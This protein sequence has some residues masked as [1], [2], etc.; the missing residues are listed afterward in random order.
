MLFNPSRR[1]SSELAPKQT[2]TATGMKK[3]NHRINEASIAKET[4][5][6]AVIF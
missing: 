6:G 3:L 1:S 4:Q 5:N 2:L